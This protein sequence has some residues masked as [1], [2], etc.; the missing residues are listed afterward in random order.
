M[1][2]VSAQFIRVSNEKIRLTGSI[3]SLKELGLY[4]M[5]SAFLSNPAF[6]VASGGMQKLLLRH[7]KNRFFSLHGAWR[8]LSAKGLL[9]RTRVPLR[10][11]RFSDYYTLTEAADPSVPDHRCLSFAE[12]QAYIKAYQP[13]I[14]PTEDFTKV[15]YE[16][17]TDPALSLSAKGL[18]AVI[19]R[20]L[21]FTETTPLTKAYLR[22]LCTEGENAFDGIFRELRV[23]GYLSLSP[24]YDRARGHAAYA[25]TLHTSPFRP[26]PDAHTQEKEAAARTQA[27]P[28]AEPQ[29]TPP[30]NTVSNTAPV[31]TEAPPKHPMTE[32]DLQ[33]QVRDQIE[34]D[35]LLPDFPQEKVDCV[36]SIL[37]SFYKAVRNGH[38]DTTTQLAGE[39]V[40]RQA[41]A[42]R[43]ALL[44][45]EDVRYVLEMGT[46]AAQ[47]R[48]IR[49]MRGYLTT[50]LY[51]AKEDLALALDA[52]ADRAL[53]TS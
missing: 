47:K 19:A 34:Y 52:F 30:K 37:L 24:V 1:Q 36:V 38:G 35:C 11:N 15:S 48:S 46:K 51:R 42:D 53:P 50:C 26:V 22:T 12:G 10:K 43:F 32:K 2:P 18:Y 7:C 31:A 4:M 5:L 45:C 44:T 6:T 29:P 14:P 40:P 20:A 8:S 25:Y 16:A 28:Q 41:V 23:A 49:N 21:R 27:R 33:K 13:Y 9:K 17:L 39:P 3:D